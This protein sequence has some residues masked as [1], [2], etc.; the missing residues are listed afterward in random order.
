MV[1]YLIIMLYLIRPTWI[2]MFSSAVVT[3]MMLEL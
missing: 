2:G 3:T 1:N